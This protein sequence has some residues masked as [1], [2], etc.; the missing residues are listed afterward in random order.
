MTSSQE[1]DWTYFFMPRGHMALDAQ[2]KYAKTK[3]ALC[4]AHTLDNVIWNIQY[5]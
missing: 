3:R 2:T 1:M 4:R 5:P